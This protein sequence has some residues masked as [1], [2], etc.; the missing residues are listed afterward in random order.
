EVHAG[1]VEFHVPIDVLAEFFIVKVTEGRLKFKIED[2]GTINGYLGG[3][4]DVAAVL[5]EGYQTNASQEFHLITPYFLENTDMM[6]N[7][8]G[9][10]DGI[11]MAIRFE[12]TTGFIVHYADDSSA[13][14]E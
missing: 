11:S 9:G 14:N 3:V 4:I 12:G 10:C 7:D 13:A 5:E 1:P 6:P 8:E 2:D